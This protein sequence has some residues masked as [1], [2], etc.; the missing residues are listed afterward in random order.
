MK[1]GRATYYTK[2]HMKEGRKQG[3]NEGAGRKEGRHTCT[4][5]KRKMLNPTNKESKTPYSVQKTEPRRVVAM[6]SAVKLINMN[7]SF[8]P[9]THF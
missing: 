6:F 9:P 3:R 4:Y 1:E 2:N 8:V 7:L 5:I